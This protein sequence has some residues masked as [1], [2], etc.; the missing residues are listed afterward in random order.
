MLQTAVEAARLAGR[1]IAKQYPAAR[2]VSYKGYRDLVTETDIAAEETILDL[3]RRRFPDHAIV[4]EET[5]RGEIA[6][7]YTW[8]IDP[9]DGTPYD[10][11][12]PGCAAT[13]GRVHEALLDALGQA[14]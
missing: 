6:A 5:A 3:I 11:R 7:G 13:N 2:D 9:L 8:V 14:G 4:S 12:F 1:L 10:V